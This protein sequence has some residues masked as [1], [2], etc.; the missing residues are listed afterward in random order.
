LYLWAVGL[1]T[2]KMVFYFKATPE[3]GDYTIYMGIDKFE[4]EELIRYGIPEDI[5]YVCMCSSIISSFAFF[6]IG[7][8]C[9]P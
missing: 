2:G 9:Y 8:V 6:R 4:N 7:I 3:V 5:W 1:S